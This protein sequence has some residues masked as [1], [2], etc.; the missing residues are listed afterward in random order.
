MNADNVVATVLGLSTGPN[1]KSDSKLVRFKTSQIQNK[2]DSKLFHF[3]CYIP[4]AC[5]FVNFN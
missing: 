3:K 2:S 1:F 4:V 5:M